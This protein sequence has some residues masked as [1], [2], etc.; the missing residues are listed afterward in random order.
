MSHVGIFMTNITIQNLNDNFDLI[1]SSCVE[2]NEVFNVSTENGNVVLMS[3]KNYKNII[4][5]INLYRIKGVHDDI[6]EAIKTPTTDFKKLKS[7]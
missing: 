4:E 5:S 1:V 7:L 2:E 6:E 3:E